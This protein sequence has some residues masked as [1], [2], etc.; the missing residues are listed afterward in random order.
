VLNHYVPLYVLFYH[1][2]RRVIVFVFHSLLFLGEVGGWGGGWQRNKTN[3]NM[4]YKLREKSSL[5]KL[6]HDCWKDS[7]LN[8]M[9]SLRT[10]LISSPNYAVYVFGAWHMWS[11]EYMIH[12]NKRFAI[13]VLWQLGWIVGYSVVWLWF[14]LLVLRKPVCFC[15]MFEISFPMWI[16]T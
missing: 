6:E 3:W 2:T 10:R 8:A 1:H 15:R 13:N 5:F 7:L 14:V 12:I 16:Y 11:M 9:S 4:W